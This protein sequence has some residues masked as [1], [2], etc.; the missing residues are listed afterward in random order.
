MKDREARLIA[1]RANRSAARKLVD[2]GFA[3]VKS[4]LAARGVG[5]RIKDKLARDAE[6]TLATGIDV[7]RQNKP[8]IAGTIG[9]LLVWFLRGPLGRLIKRAF[10]SESDEIQDSGDTAVANQYSDEE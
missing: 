8:V 5:G 10:A 2:G 7:A 3:Q 4:D 6:D 1:D 9:L